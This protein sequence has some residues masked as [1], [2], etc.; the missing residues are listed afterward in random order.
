MID[1]HAGEHV[2][3]TLGPGQSAQVSVRARLP[4]GHMVPPGTYADS[5]VLMRLFGPMESADPGVIEETSFP[6]SATIVPVCHLAAPQPSA[7][8]FST[9]IGAESRPRGEWRSLLMPEAN[10]NTGARVKLEAS[11]LAHQSA[12]APPGLDAHIDLEAQA[13]FATVTTTLMTDGPD[14]PQ[15][16]QSPISTRQTSGAGTVSLLLRLV[17]DQPL[18]PGPYQSV[19]TIKLE[20]AP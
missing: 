8:D 5:T 10:C 2:D 19:L 4:S 18:V 16:T 12:Q 6:V 17:P 15:N 7:L 9:D 14:Q 11:V 20:P 13:D 1:P 3:M